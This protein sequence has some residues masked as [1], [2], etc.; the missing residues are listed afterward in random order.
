MMYLASSI[1][2]SHLCKK[3]DT[4]KHN[5]K[6]RNSKAFYQKNSKEKPS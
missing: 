2:I 5:H 3:I 4:Q 1:D 6:G